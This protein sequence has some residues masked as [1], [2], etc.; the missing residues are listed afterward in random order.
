MAPSIFVNAQIMSCAS[1][2]ACMSNSVS[3]C[4]SGNCMNGGS[5]TCN[6]ATC[7]AVPLPD[8]HSP[9]AACNSGFACIGPGFSFCDDSECATPLASQCGFVQGS[10]QSSAGTGNPCEYTQQS[11][12]VGPGNTQQTCTST[13]T[14]GNGTG[15]YGHGYCKILIMPS[16]GRCVRVPIPE[17][18][19]SA[20]QPGTLFATL[21]PVLTAILIVLIVLYRTRNLHKTTG[22]TT[23]LYNS[24]ATN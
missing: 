15:A 18:A 19:N 16:P 21:L 17:T 2:Y 7:A 3:Y 1:G 5:V 22:E 8:F 12:C 23:T 24:A 11:I 14:G 6:S 9:P 10:C 4:A 13:C 20:I